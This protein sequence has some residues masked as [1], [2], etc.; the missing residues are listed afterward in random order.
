MS[1]KLIQD[2]DNLGVREVL[3]SLN[4]EDICIKKKNF[5]ESIEQLKLNLNQIETKINELNFDI[6]NSSDI[7]KEYC[8]KLRNEVMLETELTIKQVQDMSENLLNDINDYEEKCVYNLQTQNHQNFQEFLNE[9][10]FLHQNWTEHLEKSYLTD[11]FIE[12]ASNLY[13]ELKIRYKTIKTDLKNVI[14][15]NKLLIYNKSNLKL[16]DNLLGYLEIKSQHNFEKSIDMKKFKKIQFNDILLNFNNSSAYSDVDLFEDGKLAIVYKTA[17]KMI[18]ISIL[19]KSKKIIS[20][21]SQFGYFFYYYLIK[22]KCLKNNLIF[23]HVNNCYE[24][25][26]AVM[27]SNLEMVKSS[28]IDFQVLSL[29]ANESGIYC[30]TSNYK[31]ISFDTNLINT[32]NIGQS[33]NPNEGFYFTSAV[34][35]VYCLN[36]RLYCLCREKINILSLNTGIM[37]RSISVEGDLIAFGYQRKSIL[38]LSAYTSKVFEYSLDGDLER[39]IEIQDLPNGLEFSTDQNGKILFYSRTQSHFYFE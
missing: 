35:R 8:F 7:V 24:P 33:C 17:S 23:Y 32:I 22:L 15:S 10:K 14:F 9:M 38:V 13:K 37:L 1:S 28:K 4:T 18:E 12:N 29:D 39:E 36:E 21:S 2:T 25:Y 30:F 20:N 27:N 16:D 5:N 31:V 34:S 19:D 26:L 11:H 3:N 6:T